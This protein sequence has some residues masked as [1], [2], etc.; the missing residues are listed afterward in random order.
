VTRVVL[1]GV[2]YPHR[3]NGA[4]RSLL[5]LLVGLRERSHRP[6]VVFS[7]DGRCV[8]AYARE[9][10]D[11]RV[12]DVPPAFREYGKAWSRRG[13]SWRIRAAA[14]GLP[15]VSRQVG[16]YA[17][18]EQ[19]TLA[20]F[21]DPRALLL[22][23]WGAAATRIP[24]VLHVRGGM[25]HYPIPVRFLSQLLPR[26]LILVGEG[27]RPDILPP[28]RRKAS[29]IYNSVALSVEVPEMDTRTHAGPLTVLTLASFDPYKG[30]HHL[31]EAARLVSDAMGHEAVR[32]IWLGD[33]VDPGYATFVRRTVES[34]GLGNVEIRDWVADVR[35]FL[36]D[37]DLVVQ[38][39]VARETLELPG[40]TL[41]VRSA[42]GVPRAVIEAMALRKAAVGTKVGGIP[43]AIEHG[44]TG[45]LVPPSD[46]TALA[47][48][49]VELLRSPDRR[50]QMG[51]RGFE[52]ARSRFGQ[53]RLLD[54]TIALYDG[55]LS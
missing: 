52:L 11:V 33:V 39:T 36:L 20:H 26:R 10:I 55:L 38:P 15:D 31:A 45:L 30:Y 48:A 4:Q 44:S 28:F 21:N 22:F 54:R 34:L 50:A 19:A 41:D 24:L 51:E 6:V 14:R 47:T 43:E 2:G 25:G 40:R 13:Y 1:Y 3:L 42:E 17:R 12:L 32:F 16:R 29:V 53:Q 18:A 8:D 27:I 49:I 46:A 37:A 23:G 7:G 5:N 9:G 35:P